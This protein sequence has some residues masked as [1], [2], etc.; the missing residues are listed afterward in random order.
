MS[1]GKRS[2]FLPP[3]GTL[4]LPL[5][6]APGPGRVVRRSREVEGGP[7]FSASN[8]HAKTDTP[9]DSNDKFVLSTPW[10]TPQGTESKV[11][12]T[13]FFAFSPQS[14]TVRS[15]GPFFA[16]I[17]DQGRRDMPIRILLANEHRLFHEMLQLVDF[18]QVLKLGAFAL[19]V[20]C[21][22]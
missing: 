7:V 12:A 4:H 13:R 15:V 18:I 5:P 9:R 8:Y 22:Y 21:T 17:W 16:P 1:T 10:F 2:H 6:N 3:I 20:P 19:G 11:R 14:G